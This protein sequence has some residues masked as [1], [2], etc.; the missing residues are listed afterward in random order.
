MSYRWVFLVV[1]LHVQAKRLGKIAEVEQAAP[2][3]NIAVAQKF[4]IRGNGLGNG[5]PQG[6]GDVEPGALRIVGVAGRTLDIVCE[7]K[8]IALPHEERTSLGRASNA[9]LS[10]CGGHIDAVSHRT[11]VGDG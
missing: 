10:Q 3:T 11:M 5:F 1:V 6:H 7:G 9:D 4:P 8:R 2:A